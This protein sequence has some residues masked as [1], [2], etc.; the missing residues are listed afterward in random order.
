[1][2]SNSITSYHFSIKFLSKTHYFF[3]II[4]LRLPNFAQ[5]RPKMNNKIQVMN[6]K[7]LVMN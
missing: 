5:K 3:K 1:M 2:I 6:Y 7:L 4:K